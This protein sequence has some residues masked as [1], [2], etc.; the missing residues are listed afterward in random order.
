MRDFTGEKKKKE[1]LKSTLTYVL[2]YQDEQRLIIVK[3]PKIHGET[4]GRQRLF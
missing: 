2:M 4:K 3:V 1:D